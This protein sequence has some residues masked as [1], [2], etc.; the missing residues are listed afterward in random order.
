[1]AKLVQVAS[2]K[3]TKANVRMLKPQTQKRLHC[4]SLVFYL[5]VSS[6]VAPL[7]CWEAMPA[8]ARLT[9]CTV[10]SPPPSQTACSVRW[11]HACQFSSVSAAG[12]C[13][14]SVRPPTRASTD[15]AFS[16]KWLVMIHASVSK[17]KGDGIHWG[18]N[19]NVLCLETKVHQFMTSS[20]QPLT[21]RNAKSSGTVQCK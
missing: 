3:R 8:G 18:P 9:A 16:Y 14:S 4:L 6:G 19:S 2:Q 7:M 15:R 11:K 1:M 13:S 20:R 17:R 21:K 12:V 5:S 10:K